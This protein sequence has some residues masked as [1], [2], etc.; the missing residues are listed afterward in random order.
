MGSRERFQGLGMP[1][2]VTGS[3]RIEALERRPACYGKRARGKVLAMAMRWRA[4]WGWR[5]CRREA[6]T[7]G[8]E[9]LTAAGWPRSSPS[10][11]GLK[12]KMK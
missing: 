6:L 5:R 10:L 11:Q 9:V 2:M 4:D 12:T 3:D 1:M 7:P 8:Q